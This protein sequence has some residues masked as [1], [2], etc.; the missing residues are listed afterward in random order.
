MALHMGSWPGCKGSNVYTVVGEELKLQDDCKY[1]RYTCTYVSTSLWLQS[2][3]ASFGPL[4]EYNMFQSDLVLVRYEHTHWKCSVGV[5][6]VWCMGRRI[7]KGGTRFLLT[8]PPHNTSLAG[9]THGVG[10]T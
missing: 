5:E 3:S 7:K 1:C 6:L 10:G 8:V 2:R 4:C 9:L